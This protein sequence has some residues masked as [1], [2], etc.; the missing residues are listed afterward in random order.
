MTYTLIVS[1]EHKPLVWLSG[2]V[3]TP[4]FSAKARIQA[5]Y[6]LRMLQAGQTLTLPSLETDAGG[7]GSM[8]RA[9]NPRRKPNLANHVSRGRRRHRDRGRFREDLTNDASNGDQK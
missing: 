3:K 7:R 4:P 8:S 2:E 1:P 5:G 6:L 9:E